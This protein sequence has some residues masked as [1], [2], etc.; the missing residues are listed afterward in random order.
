MEDKFYKDGHALLNNIALELK[1]LNLKDGANSDLVKPHLPELC[2]L[3]EGA[4]SYGGARGLA[5]LSRVFDIV[6]ICTK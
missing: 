4:V 3:K 1:E 6:C 2:R 5:L